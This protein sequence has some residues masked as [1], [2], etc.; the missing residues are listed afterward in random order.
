MKPVPHFHTALSAIA[1]RTAIALWVPLSVT[2]AQTADD[3]DLFELSPFTVSTD[4]TVGYTASEST[5]GGRTRQLVKDI[6]AQIEVMTPEML[7]DFGVAGVGDAFRYSVNV[8]NKD[9]YIS[10]NDGGNAASWGGKEVGRI[11]GISPG[12]FSVSQNLFNRITRV[13]TYNINQISI[14]SGAQSLLFSLGEPAGLANVDLKTAQ[15]RDVT[16]LTTRIDSESGYRLTLDVNRKIIDKKLAIRVAALYADSPTFIKPSY[17]RDTRYYGTVTARPFTNTTV[18][19]HAETVSN[20]SNRSI[21]HLPFDWATPFFEAQRDGT[22]ASLQ[23]ATFG[24]IRNSAFYIYGASAA[25]LEFAHWPALLIPL[26]PGSLPVDAARFGSAPDPNTGTTRITFNPDNIQLIPDVAAN[27][28]RNFFGKNVRNAVDADIYNLFIEQRILSNLNFEL[29]GHWESYQWRNESLLNYSQYGYKADMNERFPA[30][31]YGSANVAGPATPNF[32]A[33]PNY[34][35][36]YA[37]SVPNGNLSI[38][39]T[40]ELRASLS[41]EPDLTKYH[42][43]L[44]VHSFLGAFSTRS[45]SEK[46]QGM[47]VR[48]TNPAIAYQ[49]FSGPMNNA[50][51]LLVL[52]HYFGPN[53]R[54]VGLPF[55]GDVSFH[56]LF[57]GF[58][59]TEPTTG[60]VLNFAGWGDPTGGSRPN[61][62]KTEID[63]WIGAWQGKFLRD[64]LIFSYGLRHD[65]VALTVINRE[66]NGPSVL[67]TGQWEWIWNIPFDPASEVKQAETSSTYGVIVRPVERLSVAYYQSS[68]F[69]LPSGSF[70]PFG[71]PIPGSNG[72]S[73]DYSLRYDDPAGR[74]FVKVNKYEVVQ[75]DNNIGYG[76]VRLNAL[77][78]EKG[79]MDIID[80]RA[81]AIAGEPT[82]EALIIDQGLTGDSANGLGQLNDPKYPVMGDILANGVE[83]TGGL[84]WRNFDVRL[85][86]AKNETYD[87]NASSDWADWIQQRA[88]YWSVLR[89]V[90]GN[91]W[92]ATNYSGPDANNYNVLLPGGGS[93][94]MTMQ[95]FYTNV[96]LGQLEVAKQRND[97]PVDTSRKYRLNLLVSYRFQDGVLQGARAGG[98]LR[99]R[100]KPMLGFPLVE[101]V[102]PDGGFPIPGL[103]FDNPY[104]GDDE[105]DVDLFAAYSGRKFFGTKMRYRVQLNAR[106][107]LTGENAYRTGRVNAWGEPVFT[108]IRTPRYY[109]LTLDLN[110]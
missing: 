11:R 49:N 43:L 88:V 66:P 42:P 22:L 50:R 53:D 38:E 74:F 35:K 63:S 87:Q 3:G 107:L 72:E 7:E 52:D 79:Y 30:I 68:T 36:V 45:S 10:P 6:P 64:R 34:G 5:L 55:G 96:V 82:Y 75:R 4:G 26:G 73:K 46:S 91:D 56:Q 20:T 40:H 37:S 31:V 105:L 77:R 23:S 13:D 19:L 58:S 12:N 95:E 80:A 108:I 98:S 84:S 57:N 78:M 32:V 83:I 8:E 59:Y 93:R 61:G 27:L 109:S 41:W 29:A 85:T 28:G 14:A 54:T 102:N 94:P 47:Q 18:R 44:G 24:A 110:F 70:T 17:D 33:N 25:P 67:P 16:R 106:N 1:W 89:D 101:I 100:S 69:N 51:R 76:N 65:D 2:Y 62:S 104:Y 21:T 81:A 60:E 39:D 92:S 99:W 15:N 9:E 97:K 86:M 48:M 71:R 103:D 90:T